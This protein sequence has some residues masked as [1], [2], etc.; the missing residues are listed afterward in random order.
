MEKTYEIGG[1]TYLQRELVLA[2]WRLLI[3]LL[4]ELEFP[5]ASSRVR[6]VLAALEAAGRLEMAL[7]VLLTEQGTL[8]QD[9]DLAALAKVFEY[10]MTPAQVAE[11]IDDF[12]ICNPAS[13]IFERLGNALFRAAAVIHQALREIGSKRSASCSQEETGADATPSSGDAPPEPPG[14][15]S[16]TASES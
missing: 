13:S 6:Q 8:P 12:F 3:P 16:S 1:K 5:P 11:V 9:K 2:E 10:A 4:Q 15:G 7:A 14:P